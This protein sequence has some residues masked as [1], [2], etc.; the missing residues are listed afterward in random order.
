MLARLE[1]PTAEQEPEQPRQELAQTS[2]RKGDSLSIE[3]VT[4]IVHVLNAEI[5]LTSA[6]IASKKGKEGNLDYQ[7]TLQI[8]LARS[9]IGIIEPWMSR[10]NS[11]YEAIGKIHSK[12]QVGGQSIHVLASQRVLTPL[13]QQDCPRPVRDHE[14]FHQFEPI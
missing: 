13:A 9:C 11:P 1:Y 10:D 8:V 2:V 6:V 14:P 4:R 7:N 5:L 12:L 3:D